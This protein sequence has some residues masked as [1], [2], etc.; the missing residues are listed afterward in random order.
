MSPVVVIGFNA[1]KAAVAVVCPV[2]PP[3]IATTPPGPVITVPDVAGSVNTVV[4]ATAGACKVT[5][6]LVSPDMT[7]ELII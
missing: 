2:P 7:T 4:P 6:P 1:L 5:D 3:L